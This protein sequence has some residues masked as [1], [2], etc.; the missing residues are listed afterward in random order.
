M[1]GAPEWR[2]HSAALTGAEQVMISAANG[3]GSEKPASTR[4]G[5]REA[6]RIV[7]RKGG[8]GTAGALGSNLGIESAPFSFDLL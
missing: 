4:A 2:R 8:S 3:G 5:R 6:I 1:N 7:K